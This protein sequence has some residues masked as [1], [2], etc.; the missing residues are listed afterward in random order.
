MQSFPTSRIFSLGQSPA[1]IVKTAE[2]LS[3]AR[4]E[5]RTFGY[6]PFSA[7][8]LTEGSKRRQDSKATVEVEDESYSLMERFKE[9]VDVATFLNIASGRTGGKRVISE[10]VEAG[11]SEDFASVMQFN[12]ESYSLPGV[13]KAEPSL[14]RMFLKRKFKEKLSHIENLGFK[15]PYRK[16][17][18]FEFNFYYLANGK[19]LNLNSAYL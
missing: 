13:E 8:F 16:K 6:I 18:L 5:E 1:W 17:F 9:C 10:E 15:I 7:R 12:G 11:I 4:D 14:R 3:E 19:S 2:I